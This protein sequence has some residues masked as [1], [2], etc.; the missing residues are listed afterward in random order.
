MEDTRLLREEIRGERAGLCPITPCEEKPLFGTGFFES[1][2]GTNKQHKK[3]EG[4][5]DD[6]G[7][8]DIHTVERLTRTEHR[9]ENHGGPLGAPSLP[10]ESQ[11]RFHFPY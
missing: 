1:G 9:A 10:V 11:R 5:R 3:N 6:L 4:L 7:W 2:R 8:R